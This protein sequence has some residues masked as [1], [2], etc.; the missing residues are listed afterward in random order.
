MSECV[1]G[2]GG[3]LLI[4]ITASAQLVCEQLR[5]LIK[6]DPARRGQ[7]VLV[8]SSVPADEVL[9]PRRSPAGPPTRRSFCLS[10]FSSAQAAGFW[11]A[12]VFRSC[13]FLERTFFNMH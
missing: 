3:A 11:A 4:T 9:I 8:S 1:R 2:W 10:S 5:A 13:K 12:S 6:R 7:L